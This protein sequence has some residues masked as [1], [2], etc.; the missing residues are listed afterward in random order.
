M[1]TTSTTPLFPSLIKLRLQ[2]VSLL[3]IFTDTGHF[4]YIQDL[5]LVVSEYNTESCVLPKE[6]KLALMGGV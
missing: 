5:S 4:P 1:R 6:S 3:D 2:S